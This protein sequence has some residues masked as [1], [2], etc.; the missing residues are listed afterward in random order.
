MTLKFEFM[1]LVSLRI[2]HYLGYVVSQLMHCKHEHLFDNLLSF[3]HR[4]AS[5]KALECRDFYLKLFEFFQENVVT[6]E[7]LQENDMEKRWNNV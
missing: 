4:K 1:C 6:R 2:L 5:K 7:K 3:F